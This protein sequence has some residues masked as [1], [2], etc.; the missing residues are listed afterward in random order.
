MK[1]IRFIK[2]RNKKTDKFNIVILAAGDAS[3]FEGNKLLYKIGKKE[4]FKYTIDLFVKLKSKR[5]DICNIVVVTKYREIMEYINAFREVKGVYNFKSSEGI[6]TSIKVG[7]GLS[8]KLIENDMLEG[9]IRE[10]KEKRFVNN[11]YIFTVSDQ[12]FLK[13]STV[14]RFISRYKKSKK[15]IGVISYKNKIYNPVI[16]NEKY[17][18]ELLLLEKDNGGKNVVKNYSDDIFTY[19]INNYSEIKDIDYKS[20]LNRK[21]GNYD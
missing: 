12:P 14:A 9:E 1:K 4:L 19:Y 17:L 10:I 21:E 16:F 15:G 6:S 13:S 7:L 20:D 2:K 8:I 5:K 11:H 18:N 3:R